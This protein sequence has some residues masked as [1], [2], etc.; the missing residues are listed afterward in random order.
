M[1]D[2][3]V[4]GQWLRVKGRLKEEFGEAAFKSWLQP[5]EL[6]GHGEGALSLAVPPSQN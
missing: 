5:L 2:E 3:T 1:N 6:A 4:R